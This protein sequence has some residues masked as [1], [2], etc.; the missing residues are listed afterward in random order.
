[1]ELELRH[2]R[3][4]LA[5]AEEPTITRAAARLHITQPALSRT[6]RRLEEELGTV[7]VERSTRSLRLTPTGE[8]FRDRCRAVLAAVDD[9]LA[10]A[11]P[12]RP[13]RLGHAWAAAGEHT[14]ELLRAWSRAHPDR[15][16]Q[17]VRVTDRTAG[18]AGGAVDVALLRGPVDD[19][20]L[21]VRMLREEPRVA[22]VAADGR[23][24]DRDEVTLAD[25][26]EEPVVL[27]RQYGTTT[28]QLWPAGG[29]PARTVDVLD[30]EEW[31][32]AIAMGRGVGVTPVSTAFFHNRPDVHYVPVRDAP[33]VPL[34]LAW[35]TS[36]AHPALPD[37]LRLAADTLATDPGRAHE[38]GRHAPAA[39]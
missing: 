8:A 7:L 25:L 21:H 37:F 20:G 18:L 14:T 26:A 28:L 16:L 24:A 23:L 35:R 32:T 5:I 17:V 29:R 10:V 4:F 9:A 33:P 39:P 34:V 30:T 3:A 6:L 31:L 19:P 36:S 27:N 38:L 2:V 13:L 12:L 15:P 1:M 22:A 11:A